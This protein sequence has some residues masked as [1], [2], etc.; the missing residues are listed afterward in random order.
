MLNGHWFAINQFVVLLTEQKSGQVEHDGHVI[1]V[2][3][4]A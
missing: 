2:E 4:Q 3:K 1:S